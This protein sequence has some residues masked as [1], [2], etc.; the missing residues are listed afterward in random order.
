TG[1]AFQR[2]LLFLVLILVN[3]ASG[4]GL[5]YFGF[6]AQMQP[7]HLFVAVLAMGVLFEQYLNQKG[8]LIS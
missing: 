6:P 5:N 4:I 3:V 7:P 2:N 1:G 8:S